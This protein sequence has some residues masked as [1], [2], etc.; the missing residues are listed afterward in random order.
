LAISCDGVTRLA[1]AALPTRHGEFRIEIIRVDGLAQEVVVLRL[2]DTDSR[3]A[4]LVRIQSE[5]LTGEVFG[6]LRCDCAAQLSASLARIG[7]EGRGAVVYLRQE[8][9]GIGLVNKVRAYALQ[10]LGL[11]TV[12]ANVALGLPVDGRDYSA[13]AAAIHYI[14]IR[15]VRLLTNNPAKRRAIEQHDIRVVSREPLLTR[16]TTYNAGYLQTKF[17]RL[18]HIAREETWE[19]SST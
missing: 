17:A 14:G 7:E 18:G 13:A 2:G 10:D 5:C 15:R 9:R 6:S 1:D 3:A 8:G 16:P 19:D 4:T 11:D 12:D